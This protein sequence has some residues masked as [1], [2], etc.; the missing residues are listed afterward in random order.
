MEV[1]LL[2]VLTIT[3]FLMFKNHYQNVRSISND[4]VLSK[5]RA[6][7]SSGFFQSKTTN[8]A[9]TVKKTDI[10]VFA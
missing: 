1:G 4:H 6:G 8:H 7:S 3:Y 2:E 10:N 9:R 5:I